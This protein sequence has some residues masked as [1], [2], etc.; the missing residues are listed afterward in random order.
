MDPSAKGG[1]RRHF[2][3]ANVMSTL[4]VFLVVAGGTALAAKVNSSK[5]IAKGSVK[6]SDVKKET[7]TSNRLKNGKAVTGDDVVDDSLTGTDVDESTLTGVPPSGP[8]GGSLTGTYPNPTLAPD[9]VTANEIAPDSVG[10]S[11]I[12]SGIVGADE[13]DTV[14]EHFSAVTDVQ[15]TTAHDG[16]YGFNT[17]TVSCGLGEDLLSVSIDWT[18]DQGH[19]E[20][21]F[22]GVNTI[23]RAVDPET[24][25]AR[26]AFDGGGGAAAPGQFQVVATCIF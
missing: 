13:L 10:S 2:S 5:D 17:Q 16:A 6:N 7:L 25:T 3:Y 15:D 9:S 4:A 11:E 20:T 8:A 21:V 22:G 1:V 18:N 19:N 26:V 12:Q 23:N 14:H 24:A